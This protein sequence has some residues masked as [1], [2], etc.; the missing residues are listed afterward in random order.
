MSKPEMVACPHAKVVLAKDDA[1]NIK[2]I[3][4]RGNKQYYETHRDRMSLPPKPPTNEDHPELTNE[5]WMRLTNKV[6]HFETRRRSDF[7]LYCCG[8]ANKAEGLVRID[9]YE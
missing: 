4:M 3:I 6:T 1:R 8:G 9:D 2:I 7:Y 5:E